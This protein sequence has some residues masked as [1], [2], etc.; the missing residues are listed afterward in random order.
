VLL[1]K[2]LDKNLVMTIKTTAGEEIIT[3]V[4]EETETTY[5]L[6]KPLVLISTPQGGFGLVPAVFSI[7]K[8]NSVMLN[9]SAV[10]LYGPTKQELA[11]QYLE[12]TTGLTVATSL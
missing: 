3:R 6:T 1:S 5:A 7:S 8:S 4:A 9:K 10:A 11:S 2:T 12:K